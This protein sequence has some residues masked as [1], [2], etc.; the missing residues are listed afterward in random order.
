MTRMYWRPHKVSRI[1]LLLVAVVALGG[2]TAAER[3]RVTERQKHYEQKMAAARA[4][5]RGFEV[6][7]T[8][9]IALGEINL[10]VDPLATGLIGPLMSPVTTNH[11]H[12]G[13]KQISV[14]PNFAALLV[15]YLKRADVE[16]GDVVALGLSGSFPAI[17]I[18][19]LTAVEA[20]GAQPV[21]ISS[22]SA[23]QFGAND[24]RLTWPDM[25]RVLVEPF[26]P[27]Y[28]KLVEEA[29][30]RLTDDDREP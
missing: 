30:R 3:F 10:E 11:G 7:R 26:R 6:V 13:A 4:A 25:E 22:V 18:A 29:E 9:R 21:V 14:N 1:E 24:P 2:L 27:D 5:Q 12:L 17:N 20:I 16:A 8:A 19:A 28:V 23:S 15:Q